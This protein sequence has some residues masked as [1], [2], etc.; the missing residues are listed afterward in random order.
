MTFDTESLMPGMVGS[1]HDWSDSAFTGY[2]PFSLSSS[3]DFSFYPRKSTSSGIPRADKAPE[4]LEQWQFHGSKSDYWPKLIHKMDKPDKKTWQ[5]ASGTTG[6][7][8]GTV[9]FVQKK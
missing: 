1:H 9:P 5:V 4:G 8:K 2:Q 7:N 6:N 3:P